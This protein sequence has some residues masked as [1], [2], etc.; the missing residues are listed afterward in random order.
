MLTFEAGNPQDKYTAAVNWKLRGLGA[1]LR[2]TRY[3][4][5]LS[6][7]TTAANDLVLGAATVVDLEARYQLNDRIKFALGADNILDEYPDANPPALNG[8]GNTPFSNYAPFGRSGRFVYGRLT[9]N[10]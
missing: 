8:T 4:D 9:F 5:V 6:P 7:G 10:F 2:A 1:T 3:G